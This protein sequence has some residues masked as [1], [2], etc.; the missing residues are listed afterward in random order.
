MLPKRGHGFHFVDMGEKE[1]TTDSV[2]I[3]SQGPK[4]IPTV[5]SSVH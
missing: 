3:V 1:E 5:L 4:E 2:I